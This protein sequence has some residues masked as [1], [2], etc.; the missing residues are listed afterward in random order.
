MTEHAGGHADWQTPLALTAYQVL[1]V[2][3]A[4]VAWALHDSGGALQQQAASLLTH[5]L[6][7]QELLLTILWC[8]VATTA[9]SAYAE[10]TALGELSSSEATVIY[11]T[12][13][14]WGVA[15]AC[16][17]LGE[18]MGPSTALGGACV[19]LA[20]LT[21]ATPMGDH[22]A[23]LLGLGQGAATAA[24]ASAEGSAEGSAEWDA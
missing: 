16:A 5:P 9:A 22:L 19:I 1:A 10:A 4:S 17:M 15:F 18:T 24:E 8:G 14:L 2:W 23:S 7:Q 13:P 12:E 3:V 11:S 20:C 6:A 21:S